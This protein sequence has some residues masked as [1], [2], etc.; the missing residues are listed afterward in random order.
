M[1]VVILINARNAGVHHDTCHVIKARNLD[2]SQDWSFH[3][4][5]GESSIQG[6]EYMKFDHV[7]V[8]GGDKIKGYE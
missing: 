5:I 8:T 1:I 3:G 7:V 2:V 4:N 6:D